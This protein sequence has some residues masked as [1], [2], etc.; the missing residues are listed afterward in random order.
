[1]EALVFE[2][3]PLDFWGPALPLGTLL[4]SAIVAAALPALHAAASTR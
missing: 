2:V 4:L 1:V 3:T